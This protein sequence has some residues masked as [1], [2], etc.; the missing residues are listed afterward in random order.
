MSAT[1]TA[2]TTATTTAVASAPQLQKQQPRRRRRYRHGDSDDDEDDDGGA[3]GAGGDQV[4][5]PSV[6]ELFKA[7]SAAE[8]SFLQHPGQTFQVS[9]FFFLFFPFF[10]RLEEKANRIHYSFLYII[11]C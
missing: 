4:K 11:S 10:L 7:A 1:A 6:G 5:L 8:P 2:T 3:G 9:F